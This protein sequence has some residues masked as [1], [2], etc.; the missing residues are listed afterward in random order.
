MSTFLDDLKV[1]DRVIMRE[2]RSVGF[3]GGGYGIFIISRMTP[4]RICI[5]RGKAAIP[6]ESY[7][8]QYWRDTGRVVG[9]HYG[10]RLEEAT[11]EAVAKI[12]ETNLRRRL[13]QKVRA[14]ELN[15]LTTD[16]LTKI[17]ALI[18]ADGTD[19]AVEP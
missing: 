4:K 9:D 19:R 6:S 16:T 10:N 5:R 7:E 11:P 2:Y 13:A 3:G 14:I 17:A 15:H 8:E 1:G 12:K 18:D